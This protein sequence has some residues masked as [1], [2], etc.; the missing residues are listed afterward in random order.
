MVKQIGMSR[1]FFIPLFL[2]ASFL[3][4]NTC[5]QS[6]KT[7]TLP[8]TFVAS[9]PCSEGSRPLPGIP[10]N[11]ECE[12]INWKLR[13]NGEE[14]KPANYTLTYTW[15]MSK[16]GTSGFMNGGTTV[17]MQGKWSAS[18]GTATDPNAIVY[19]LDPDKPANSIHFVKLTDQLLHLLDK[20]KRLMVGSPAWSYTLNREQHE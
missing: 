20:S 6:P 19:T 18:K 9:S 7:S 3:S 2:L 11:A 14:A 1:K 15:G 12:F 5:S 17:I 4:S 8:L 13:L 10:A 16:P